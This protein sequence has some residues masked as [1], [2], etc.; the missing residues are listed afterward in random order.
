VSCKKQIGAN[1][2]IKEKMTPADPF[3]AICQSVIPRYIIDQVPDLDIKSRRGRTDYIDF[4]T[5]ADMKYEFMKGV[6]CF[7]RAFIA[8][9]HSR[10]VHVIFQRYTD[11]QDYWTD[12]GRQAPPGADR[13]WHD[14]GGIT[15][16]VRGM[17]DTRTLMF[18]RRLMQR[19]GNLTD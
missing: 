19:Y 6:D 7:R 14:T 10:G 4:L 3:N 1:I 11:N 15:L 8:Y 5:P 9:R 2:K 16:S 12:A 18:R 17:E 13:M